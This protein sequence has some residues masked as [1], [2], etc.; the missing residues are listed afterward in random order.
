MSTM[1]AHDGFDQ[2]VATRPVPLLTLSPVEWRVFTLSLA[3]AARGGSAMAA[4]R[5]HRFA[6]FVT[7]RDVPRPLA[8][9]RLEALRRF[10]CAVRGRRADA[11]ALGVGLIELGYSRDQVRALRLLSAG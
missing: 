11:R 10:V 3:E 1:P 4:T 9:P 7:G 8:N 5:W 6:A 2:T